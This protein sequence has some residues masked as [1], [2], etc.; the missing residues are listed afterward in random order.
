MQTTAGT[1]APEVVNRDIRR[2]TIEASV[3]EFKIN[4]GSVGQFAEGNLDIDHNSTSDTYFKLFPYIERLIRFN[5]K[6]N[7]SFM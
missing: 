7:L 6:I 2:G 3:R 5:S 4:L 1:L